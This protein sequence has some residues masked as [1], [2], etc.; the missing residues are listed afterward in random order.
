MYAQKKTAASFLACSSSVFSAFVLFFCDFSAALFF[1]L[2]VSSL[3]RRLS[4]S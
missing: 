3:A 1:E 2:E 4:S